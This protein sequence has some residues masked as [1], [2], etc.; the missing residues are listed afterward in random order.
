MKD[1]LRITVTWTQRD[2]LWS[3]KRYQTISIEDN[4]A[5]YNKML[6]IIKRITK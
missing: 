4:E 1:T 5:K 3:S 2:E 6:K